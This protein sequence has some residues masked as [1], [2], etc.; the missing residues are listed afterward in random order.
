MLLRK[1]CCY[2]NKVAT[3]FERGEGDFDCI[4]NLTIKFQYWSCSDT[5]HNRENLVEVLK[6]LKV[7]SDFR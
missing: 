4:I 7:A 5:R 3:I 2:G 1:L 6:E